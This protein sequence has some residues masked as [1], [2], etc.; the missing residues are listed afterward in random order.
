[1]SKWSKALYA[2]IIL[3]LAGLSFVL[4]LSDRKAEIEWAELTTGGDMTESGPDE[5]ETQ[6]PEVPDNSGNP[7]IME[8][9]E[10]FLKGTLMIEREGQQ[11]RVNELFWDNEIEYCY[12]DMDGDG[13]DELHIRDSAVYYVIKAGEEVLQI[14]FE[15]WWDCEPVVAD[16]RCGFWITGTE[17]IDMERYV[18]YREEQ[19]ANRAENELEWTNRRLKEFVTWQEAYIDFINKPE[20]TIWTSG[21]SPDYSLIYVDNDDIPELYINTGYSAGGEF[22][23]SFYDGNVRAL[24]RDRGGIKYMEYGGLF[25]SDWGNAGFYPCDVYMLERGTFSEIGTGWYSD[26]AD[27]QG[28]IYFDYFWDGRAV[29]EAAYESHIDE[30][31]DRSKC[32]EPSLMYSKGEIL[33]V[34]SDWRTGY[35]P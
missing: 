32:T 12:I 33:E 15:S 8:I 20:R 30:L 16:K 2:L 29:T 34:L 9:Y 35:I 31:I 23:V 14:I 10:N 18:Q 24:N 22:V 7:N 28:N 17:A 4:R 1:M 21:T 19:I 3:L 26:Y 25:Y 5:T 6:E 13:R 11:V 27:E